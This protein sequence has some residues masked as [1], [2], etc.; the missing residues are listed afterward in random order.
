[1]NLVFFVLDEQSVRM[2]NIQIYVRQLQSCKIEANRHTLC[3]CPK[4]AAF[5]SSLTTRWTYQQV[6]HRIF[7]LPICSRSRESA[8]QLFCSL[9]STQMTLTI[10]I[11]DSSHSI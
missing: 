11:N 1:M 8:L 3:V 10:H 2:L 5:K 9:Q 7:N 4:F 6:F